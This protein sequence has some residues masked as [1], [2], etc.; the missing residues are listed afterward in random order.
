M[1]GGGGRGGGGG[2]QMKPF[3]SVSPQVKITIWITSWSQG[4][5]QTPGLG[6]RGTLFP[7]AT[8]ARPLL[9]SAQAS[10]FLPFL[11]VHG[12][13]SHLTSGLKVKGGLDGRCIDTAQEAGS[14][15]EGEEAAWAEHLFPTTI[16][17]CVSLDIQRE[18]VWWYSYLCLQ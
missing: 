13:L 6:A 10:C 8:A 5:E 14:P 1:P 12:P 2:L 11:R 15:E 7:T 3:P 18:P 9:L 16:P 4:G 17:L